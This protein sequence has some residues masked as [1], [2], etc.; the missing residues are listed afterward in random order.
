MQ[1][2]IVIFK[3]TIKSFIC[4]YIRA[5]H[6]LQGRSKIFHNGTAKIEIKTYLSKKENLLTS[7][8]ALFNQDA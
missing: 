2:Y 3:P 7:M 8:I 6:M 4:G 5:N 1:Y